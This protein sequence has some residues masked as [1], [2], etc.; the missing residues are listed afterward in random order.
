MSTP[1]GWFEDPTTPGTQRW[2]DGQSWTEHTSPSVLPAQETSTWEFSQQADPMPGVQTDAQTSSGAITS[3]SLGH[4]LTET[5][6]YPNNPAWTASPQLENDAPTSLP[7]VLAT[8]A[9]VVVP[10]AAEFDSFLAEARPELPVQLSSEEY[11]GTADTGKVNSGRP[12]WLIPVVSILALLLLASLARLF[13]AHQA[14]STNHAPAATAGEKAWSAA[15]QAMGA[16]AVDRQTSPDNIAVVCS[17]AFDNLASGTLS[18]D[19]NSVS[20]DR[21][22]ALYTDGCL[23]RFNA[24][25][26]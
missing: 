12:K 14:D 15:G 17:G 1:A 9:P 18:N 3:D 8:P 10:D 5:P 4:G 20:A 25:A 19:M 16:M 2:W 26:K 22:R 21:A 11:A 7:V 13:L 23:S 6:G 24:P